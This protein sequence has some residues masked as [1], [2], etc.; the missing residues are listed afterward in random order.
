MDFLSWPVAERRG[1][2][3]AIVA[4]IVGVCL[5]IVVT[6]AIGGDSATFIALLVVTLI[7]YGIVSGKIQEFSA[8]G[9]WVAKFQ[10]AA[11]E[12]VEPTG[13]VDCIQDV[14][15][16]QKRGLQ[17]L[18][19][20]GQHLEK[21]KPIALTLQFGRSSYNADELRQYIDTLRTADREMSVLFLNANGQLVTW[22]DGTT[23]STLL[24]DHDQ[25]IQL[26][27]AVRD[28]NTN[29]FQN[30]P[31]F[32]SETIT[33]DRS[34]AEALQIMRETNARTM[35]VV[36]NEKQPI[37]VVKRDDIIARLLVELGSE[38]INSSGLTIR[39]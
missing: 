38:L 26:L 28:S 7:V 39:F 37:G 17:A 24:A 12:K 13:L 18:R 15:I 27:Q 30:S 32:R 10:Q 11:A 23:L 5:A 33:K 3:A 36:N 20:A 29:Y 34:N 25:S 2:C 4:L 19:D 35:V 16:V 8:P 21:G 22:T 1:I 6:K 14:Q 31:E 9:G